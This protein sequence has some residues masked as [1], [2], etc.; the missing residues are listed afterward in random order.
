MRK[1]IL[2]FIIF[3]PTFCLFG[4]KQVIPL[5]DSNQILPNNFSF[6]YLLPKTVIQVNIT[7][8]KTK[9]I[10]GYYADYA[11]KFL[12]LSN[13][14]TDNKTSYKVKDV[15]LTSY[16]IPDNQYIYTVELTPAQIKNDYL[17]HIYDQKIISELNLQLQQYKTLLLKCRIFSNT[18]QT[19]HTQKL[20]TLL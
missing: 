3:L 14:I 7:V 6:Y 18:I 10:K 11:E 2:A 15:S 5:A 4:Q 13:V 19:L 16:E 8:V 17:A 9:E 12:G 1:L 20:M